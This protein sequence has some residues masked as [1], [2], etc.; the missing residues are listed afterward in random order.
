MTCYQPSKLYHC[1]CCCSYRY[2]PSTQRILSRAKIPCA[3][4]YCW[5]YYGCCCST[6]PAGIVVDVPQ[7]LPRVVP[8]HSVSGP[9]VGIHLT[10]PT[11]RPDGSS[12]IF[13][14][15]FWWWYCHS[16]V[17]LATVQLP[18][19]YS[20]MYWLSSVAFCCY[21]SDCCSCWHESLDADTFVANI[22]VRHL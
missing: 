14:I 20:S 8:V 9:R 17:L 5:D 7:R 16:V 1:C 18:I 13:A 22:T 21:Y 11:I 15:A 6:A 19:D 4:G 10:L 12:S 2:H 3:N